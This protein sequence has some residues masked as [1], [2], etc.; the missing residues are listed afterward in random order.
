MPLHDHFRGRSIR[1]TLPL[2]LTADCVIPIDLETSYTETGELLR[3]P[4]FAD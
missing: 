2:W 3:L 1:R 4:G